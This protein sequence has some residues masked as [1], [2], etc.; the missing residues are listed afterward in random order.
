MFD[1]FLFFA[2][3]LAG[4][5]SADLFVRCWNS[6]LECGAALVLFLRKKIPAKIFLSRMGSSVPLIIL[7]FLL[8]ILCFKIYFSILGYGRAEFEQLGYFLGAVPRTGVYLI[9]AGKM[10]DSMFKP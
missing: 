3:V 6:F 1:I 10:I 5:I 8:L 4:I 7:C 2:A 9:S